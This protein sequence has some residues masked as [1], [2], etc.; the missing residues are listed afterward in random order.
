MEPGEAGYR[1]QRDRSRKQLLRLPCSCGPQ[2]AGCHNPR[3]STAYTLSFIPICPQPGHI[4]IQELNNFIP[5]FFFLCWCGRQRHVHLFE[6]IV[7]V[8]VKSYLDLLGIKQSAVNG[9]FIGQPGDEQ[10]TRDA[11]KEELHWSPY[12]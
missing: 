7:A 4:A 10:T 5:S 12:V 6:E 9:A 11:D 1:G 8:K 2:P 3:I